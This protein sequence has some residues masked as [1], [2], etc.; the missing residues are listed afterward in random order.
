[1]EAVI[2]GQCAT[3]T[4][5]MSDGEGG[6]GRTTL[7]GLLTIFLASRLIL[8]VVALIVEATTPLVPDASASTAPLLRSLTN[9]DGPWYVGIAANGYHVE[10]LKG[11]FHDY[12]FFPL[13]P[14]LIRAAGVF[15][16]GNLPLA[17]VAISNVAYAGALVV[18]ERMSRPIVGARGAL[19][20]AAFLTFAPG[21]VAFGMAYSDS[22][23]LLLSLA[24]VVAAQRRSWAVMS[25]L[26]GL[27][28]LCRLP[29]VVLIVPLAMTMAAQQPR[30]T[31]QDFLWLASGPIALAGYLGFVV[32]MTGDAFAWLR[33]QSAWNNPPDSYGPPGMPSIPSSMLLFLLIGVTVFYLFQLV[34][35]RTSRLPR[36]HVAYAIASLLALAVSARIVSLPRY[37]AVLWPFPWLLTSRRS[38]AF[39]K[40][41][42][43][44][45][46]VAFVGFAYL[47]FT[48]LAP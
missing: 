34:Y 47:D 38:T 36:A 28:A 13:Y 29:G 30:P 15:T 12:V 31:R 4:A 33:A 8:V 35:L 10:A 39:M 7:L 37:L 9:S 11:P 23:F 24:A 3:Y 26:F 25:V 18:F 46:V 32:L 43:G 41:A 2:G 5:T 27:A 40:A 22:V 42:L 48:I 14:L 6:S 1:V 45:F 20:A 21:A 17:A 44:L 19:I 16:L